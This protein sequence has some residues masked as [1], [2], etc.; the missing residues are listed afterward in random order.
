MRTFGGG[1]G[2]KLGRLLIEERMTSEQRIH[3]T[4]RKHAAS[5][6]IGELLVLL[7]LLTPQQLDECL[8]LQRDRPG[9]RIGEI[10]LEKQFVGERPLLRTL[11]YQFGRPYI[12]PDLKLV[13]VDLMRRL[14]VPYLRRLEAVPAHSDGKVVTV[15]T[16]DPTRTDVV[17]EFRASLRMP[18]ELAIGPRAAILRTIHDFEQ[19]HRSGKAP[20][21]G[22]HLQP[23][24]QPQPQVLQVA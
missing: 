4:V 8:A 14:S 17:R 5:Y 6:R 24:A 2:R 16:A 12:E 21:A 1:A 23:A 20:R 15:V 13:D 19:L 22:D 7:D 11:S 3:E 9:T 10:A 18:I